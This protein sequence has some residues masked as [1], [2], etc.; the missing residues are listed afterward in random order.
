MVEIVDAINADNTIRKIQ[1][2]KSI[3]KAIYLK[4]FLKFF[5]YLRHF[6]CK[7]NPSHIFVAWAVPQN[8]FIA[9]ELYFFNLHFLSRE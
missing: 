3:V 2:I 8:Q 4:L 9:I 5:N 1:W 6:L 7:Q